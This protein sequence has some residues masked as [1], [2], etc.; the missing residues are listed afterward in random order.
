LIISML[1]DITE[2]RQA[3]AERERLIRELQEAVR[4]REVF[5]SIASHE[6]R[7]PLTPLQL[8]LQVLQRKLLRRPDEPPPGELDRSIQQTRRLTALVETLLDVSRIAS[9]RFTCQPKT[10]DLAELARE[11]VERWLPAAQAAGCDLSLEAPLPV[12]TSA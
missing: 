3:E 11:L 2:S 5:L 6:L 9:G 12:V 7:T 10:I 4:A 1:E 8:D